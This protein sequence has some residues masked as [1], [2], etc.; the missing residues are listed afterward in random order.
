MNNI[1][2]L[3]LLLIGIAGVL[4]GFFLFFYIYFGYSKK[5]PAN[6]YLAF[7]VLLLTVRMAKSILSS[8][9]PVNFLVIHIGLAAFASVGPMLFFYLRK[10]MNPKLSFYG[11]EFLHFIP[12]FIVLSSGLL[13]YPQNDPIWDL[14]YNLI[15][16]QIMAY[17]VLSS[18]Y[19]FKIKN[20]H[21]VLPYKNNWYLFII[22]SVA[23]IWM[24]YAITWWI[25]LLP[26]LSGTFLFCLFIYTLIYLWLNKK[27]INESFEKYKNSVLNKSDSSAL[28]QKLMRFMKSSKPFLDNEITLSKLA[29]QLETKSHLLSQI[30]NE[31]FNTNFFDF[32]NS[33]R[34]DEVKERLVSPAFAKL[35]IAAIAYDC[36]FN[37]ISSFNSAFKKK[38]KVSPREY[39]EKHIK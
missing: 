10:S 37:S 9:I 20:N 25:G 29:S 15:M 30:I 6:K 14:R 1:L 31:N 8:I 2:L 28:F 39:R 16:V 12:S 24:S 4:N 26:Y 5:N 17:L 7:L 18:H 13:P 19:F 22:S 34:I 35:T 32:I 23:L 11:V 27:Q 38:E 21:M 36:G 33:Y 3:F